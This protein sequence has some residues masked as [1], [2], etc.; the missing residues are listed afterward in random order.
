MFACCPLLRPTLLVC[1]ALL[2]LMWACSPEPNPGP[3][4]PA[5]EAAKPPVTA[6]QAVVD[7]NGPNYVVAGGS[8]VDPIGEDRGT[9]KAAGRLVNQGDGLNASSVSDET[10]IVLGA[11]GRMA[12]LDRE[13]KLKSGTASTPLALPGDSKIPAYFAAYGAKNNTLD[14][15]K[16]ESAW[17]VGGGKGRVAYIDGA[18]ANPFPDPNGNQ[19]TLFGGSVDLLDASFD[20]VS[21]QWLVGGAGGQLVSLTAASLTEALRDETVLS[22][23]IQRILTNSEATSDARWLVVSQRQATLFPSPSPVAFE[24]GV[25]VSAAASDGAGKVLLG[26]EDGR[27]MLRDFE[28]VPQ[29]GGTWTDALPTIVESIH[30]NG[31]DW[32]V[33][34]KEGWA[35]VFDATGAPKTEPV[36][37]G[38]GSDLT[39]A[40]WNNGRWFI[41]S[42]SSIIF[43]VNDKL[44][45][46]SPEEDLLEGR[47]ILAMASGR[48]RLVIAGEEGKYRL[49]TSLGQPLG[50]VQTTP[51]G[52]TIHDVSWD[53]DGFLMVGEGGKATLIDREGVPK[54]QDLTMLGG[55]TAHVAAW[56][57]TFWL[58]GGE[59]GSVQRLREN[60]EITGEPLILEDI[61]TVYA[62]GWNGEQWMV[63]G[64]LNNEGRIRFV[65]SDGKSK[66]K[67]QPIPAID[68]IYAL[69]WSGFEWIVGG[70][71]GMVQF[72]SASGVPRPAPAPQ[73]VLSGRTIRAILFHEKTYLVA[74]D[75]GL[76]QFI[77]EEF[78]PLSSLALAK[79]NDLH[80]AVWTRPRGYGQ[81]EC[82]SDT[83]CYRGRCLENQAGAK[84]CCDVACDRGC[85]SCLKIRNNAVDGLCSPFV[86]GA[87]PLT[88]SACP[89]EPESSCGRTGLCDG[90]GDCQLHAA[91]VVCQDASCEQNQAAQA[92]LCDGQGMCVTMD[93]TDCAPYNGC[94]E[95][96]RCKTS[97]QADTDCTTGFACGA[98]GT[99]VDRATLPPAD[100]GIEQDMSMPPAPKASGGDGGCSSAAAVPGGTTLPFGLLG[101]MILGLRRRRR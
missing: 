1:L 84:F 73:D 21:R 2:P 51:S 95:A 64:A 85:E 11:T 60:G 68:T 14:P 40:T 63:A 92:A 87:M 82:L 65:T 8:F 16:L 61:E 49:L 20:P 80:D 66:I 4:S 19:A 53:G 25:V 74:G 91:T 9:D 17:L 39:I 93:A 97:C 28:Q 98:Q 46:P 23:P 96:G 41:G 5:P 47:T 12:V 100:M 7:P 30:H 99:C 69:D 10:W 31:I 34:G 26:A 36:Q 45:T 24:E 101:L 86:A 62:A 44:E 3:T 50:A 29:A 37:R 55:K 94:S 57:G 6:V 58:V 90:Q 27:V 81:G 48:D 67:A 72:V 15:A 70:S 56:S 52:A 71:G 78:A 22:T 88:P 83:A 77:S 33:L 35:R 89:A 13:G 38:D 32:L 18:T 75:G 42:S 59:G 43:E 54:G 79:F 76:V